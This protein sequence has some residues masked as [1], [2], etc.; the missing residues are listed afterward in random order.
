MRT[1]VTGATGLVGRKL[2]SCVER[3]VVL[4]RNVEQAAAKLGPAE[5]HAW[6]PERGLPPAAAIDGVDVVFNF[7][8]EPIAEGRWSEEKKRRIRDSRILGTRNLVAGLAAVQSRPKVLVSASAVGYYGD[9][10][11]T[12]LDETAA[13]GRGFL[14]ELCGDWE[15]EAMA[16]EKL[17]IRVICARLGVVLAPEGG[18]LARMLP[19]FRMG[20][21]GRIG[22]GQQWMSWIHVDDVVGILLH[23]S[24]REEVRGPVNVVGTAPVTNADFTRALGRAVHRPAFLRVPKTALR[25]AIGEMSEV[26]T[27]SQRVLPTVA[28]RSGY[29]FKHADLDLALANLVGS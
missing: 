7:A 16:A 24:R 11:D 27:D 17:G 29:D 22:N 6:E 15:R 2:V 8:G 14:A 25:L 21:G 26:L 12:E 28:A 19:A 9:R 10:G 3:A 18:A 13:P 1:L 4:T 23:V 5:L 20:V